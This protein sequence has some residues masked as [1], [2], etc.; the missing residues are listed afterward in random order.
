MRLVFSECVSPAI[1]V[2]THT[3]TR[4][5]AQMW[6]CPSRRWMSVR[7]PTP[8][9]PGA[10]SLTCADVWAGG[11]PTRRVTPTSSIFPVVTAARRP[12]TVAT[13][14][15]CC[16]VIRAVLDGRKPSL[17][18]P[19]LHRPPCLH[20]LPPSSPS[21]HPHQAPGLQ[22]GGAFIPVKSLP[23]VPLTSACL[24]LV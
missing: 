15:L 7:P 21:M 17:R 20:S 12:P 8:H 10:F 9:P 4:A 16:F 2:L 11:V 5:Y 14:L 24:D 6:A 13:P 1:I 18:P 19:L 23:M 22:D 3:H